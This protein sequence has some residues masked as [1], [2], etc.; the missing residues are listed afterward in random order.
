LRSAYERLRRSGKSA[1][2]KADEKAAS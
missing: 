1:A 2:E